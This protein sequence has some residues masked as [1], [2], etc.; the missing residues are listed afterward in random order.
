MQAP[1]LAGAD[2]ASRRAVVRPSAR[3]PS[4]SSS[5]AAAP[6][7]LEKTTGEEAVTEIAAGS[8]FFDPRLFDVYRG[9]TARPAALF[10]LPVVRRP[11]PGIVTVL[12]GGWIASGAARG[13]TGCPSPSCPCGLRY[14]PREGAGE[15][16]TPLL[17]QAADGCA[18]ATASGSVT[19]RRA[20]SAST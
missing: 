14:D 5:T 7:A 2:R 11:G 6:A 18:S 4:W 12:G 20:N 17:G 15:V 10:A 16:Q 19:P 13:R 1:V 9:F 3:S 8:G